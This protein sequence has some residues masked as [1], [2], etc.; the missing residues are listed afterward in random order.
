MKN[1]IAITSLLAAGTLCANAAITTTQGS[2]S[3]N[4]ATWALDGFSNDYWAIQLEFSDMGGMLTGNLELNGSMN[5]IFQTGEPTGGQNTAYFGLKY[6]NQT[7]HWT[8]DATLTDGVWTNNGSKSK[9]YI[10]RQ[11]TLI[12]NNGQFTLWIGNE[13]GD[14][15]YAMTNTSADTG[16]LIATPEAGAK[17]LSSTIRGTNLSQVESFKVATF[18]AEDL[19]ADNGFKNVISAMRNYSIP[20]PSAFGLLAGLGALALAGT[21]RRRRK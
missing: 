5:F 21:R 4:S 10:G 18:T 16:Y 8:T 15:Q 1:I 2:V 9:Y 14:T 20:E 11:V 17:N 12:N 3:S 7:N 19:A 6:D 13:S